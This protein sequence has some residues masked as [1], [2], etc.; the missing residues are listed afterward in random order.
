MQDDVA[1]V[2]INAPADMTLSCGTALPP[3]PTNVIAI[4]TMGF[5]QENIPVTFQETTQ[6]GSCNGFSS[7]T[8]FWTAV[9]LCNNAKTVTQK[10]TYSAA[11]QNLGLVAHGGDNT[12]KLDENLLKQTTLLV[13]T[14]N[15]SYK[16]FKN[17][18]SDL[19]KTVEVFTFEGRQ[20]FTTD[21]FG[22]AIVQLNQYDKGIYI[23]RISDGKNVEIKKVSRQ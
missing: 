9:D 19:I 22:R 14:E 13:P 8:R 4:D 20:I 12:G 15:Q 5:F 23:V 7:V 1:P 2:I 21:S 16:T 3:A 18:D 6:P 10:I 11:S 17:L